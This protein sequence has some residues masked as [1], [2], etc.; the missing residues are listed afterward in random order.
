MASDA[1]GVRLA[2]ISQRPGEVAEALQH[3]RIELAVGRFTKPAQALRLKP[4]YDESMV[5]V[6]AAGHPLAGRRISM[7]R[8]VAQPHLLVAPGGQGDFQGLFD[9]QLDAL[10]L[11]RRVVLSMGHFLAAPWIAAQSNAVV[12]IP[13]RLLPVVAGWQLRALTVPLQM[14]SFQV[15]MLWRERSQR[16]PAHRGLRQVVVEA[17]QP[18]PEP[19]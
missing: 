14:P 18:T 2:V 4:L 10:G 17:L 8:F 6:V 7:A 5:A 9:Q 15:S 19:V 13:R 16:E 12:L 1:P 11:I 3:E